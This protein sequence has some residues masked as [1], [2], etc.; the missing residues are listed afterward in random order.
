M[1]PV[2]TNAC[3]W[4]RFFKWSQL[5]AQSWSHSPKSTNHNE[6]SVLDYNAISQAFHSLMRNFI[7]WKTK[8][9]TWEIRSTIQNSDSGKQYTTR[10]VTAP[11][12]KNRKN[13][14]LLFMHWLKQ[15]FR[16]FGD[17]YLLYSFFQAW[18]S[19][20]WIS[21]FRGHFHNTCRFPE[22]V[23]RYSWKPQPEM[24]FFPKINKNST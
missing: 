10:K 15:F 6:W 16:I 19:Q 5:C 3:G 9:I 23:C 7:T 20:Y 2:R 18:L 8:T 12:V 4:E 17:L 24:V 11:F 14:F 13:N 22:S 21:E 1:A